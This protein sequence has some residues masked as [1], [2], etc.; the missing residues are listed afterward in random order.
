MFKE[1]RKSYVKQLRA[2][3]RVFDV[4]QIRDHC[5]RSKVQ[6]WFQTVVRSAVSKKKPDLKAKAEKAVALYESIWKA[7][8]ARVATEREAC[9]P[10]LLRGKNFLLLYKWEFGSKRLPDGTYCYKDAGL[11]WG[12]WQTWEAQRVTQL[13]VKE[14]TSILEGSLDNTLARRVH[15]NWKVN[16]AEPLGQAGTEGFD[17]HGVRPDVRPTV[18]AMRKDTNKAR[19][20]TFKEASYVITR[21]DC[22]SFRLILARLGRSES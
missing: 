1:A 17:F 10:I 8:A 21:S 4:A 11:L 12:E 13:R 15:L 5:G 16:L 2:V 18:V 14:T 20:A 22:Q 6:E 3:A 19:G 9:E 7:E